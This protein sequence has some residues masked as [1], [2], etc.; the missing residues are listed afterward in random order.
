MVYLDKNPA[1]YT[2]LF[3]QHLATLQTRGSL[4]QVF[5]SVPGAQHLLRCRWRSRSVSWKVEMASRQREVSLAPEGAGQL[6][7]EWRGG[8]QRGELRR[9]LTRFLSA[10]CQVQSPFKLNKSITFKITGSDFVFEASCLLL[11]QEIG[12]VVSAY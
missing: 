10:K 3:P 5:R 11:T 2:W 4:F 6:T 1:W 12:W 8:G 7:G 9:A